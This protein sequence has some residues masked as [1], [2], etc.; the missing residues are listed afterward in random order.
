LL[1]KPLQKRESVLADGASYFEEGGKDRT[2]LQPLLQR[3]LL[4]VKGGQA[5]VRG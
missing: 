4:A 2:M 3:V 5:E 1:V